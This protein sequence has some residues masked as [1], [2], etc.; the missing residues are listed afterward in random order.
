MKA[1]CG[2]IEWRIRSCENDASGVENGRDGS[3]FI[4]E[5]GEGRGCISLLSRGEGKIESCVLPGWGEGATRICRQSG[6]VGILC[7][8]EGR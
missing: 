3:L 1:G 5:V 4:L 2:Q 8:A 7:L 6:V